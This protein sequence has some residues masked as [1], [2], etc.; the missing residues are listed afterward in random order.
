MAR[1]FFETGLLFLARSIAPRGIIFW[2]LFLAFSTL[3]AEPYIAMREG[4]KCAQCH[5]NKTGGGKRT[6]YGLIFSQNF[7]PMKSVSVEGQPALFDGRLNEFISTGANLRVTGVS[8]FE[9][10][11]PA[12]DQVESS[13]SIQLTE[14]DVYLQVDLVKDFLTL[15][16]DEI[17][18]PSALNRESFGMVT[19]EPLG[20]Y[21]KAGRMLLPYG[22]RLLDDDAFVRDRTGY[23]FNR[24]DVGIEVGITPGPCL[25]VANVTNSRLTLLGSATYRRFTLGGSYGQ[26]TEQGDDFT[27]G[28]FGGTTLRPFT[29]LGEVDLIREGEIDQ[30]ALLA[31]IDCLVRTGLNAKFTYEFF[32]RNRDVANSRDGQERFTIGVEPFLTQFLQAGL[33][34][35]INRFIP[36]GL[37]PNQDSLI[38][39]IH[40]FF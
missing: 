31:E 18:S 19:M 28:A 40:T 27:V 16:L 10:A 33:F 4:L 6:P 23:S 2:T 22:L 29:F 21:V 36:Q 25:A 20:A 11:S 24:H 5:V 35:R 13:S 34:Y 3:S 14:A 39:Q 7:L 9:Y 8:L 26:S 12:G 15:Y 30:I 38:L 1:R 17:V 32:D 37:S